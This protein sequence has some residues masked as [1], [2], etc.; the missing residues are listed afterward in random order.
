MYEYEFHF[1]DATIEYITSKEK[2]YLIDD[3]MPR[4]LI[5]DIDGICHTIFCNNL[6]YM[7]E[8]IDKPDTKDLHLG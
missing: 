8:K 6:N 7:N 1:Q 2:A 4:Y 5:K 3:N